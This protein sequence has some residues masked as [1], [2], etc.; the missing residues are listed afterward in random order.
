MLLEVAGIEIN[1]GTFLV[2]L[3]RML[4]AGIA[5]AALGSDAPYFT[6]WKKSGPGAAATVTPAPRRY[7]TKQKQRRSRR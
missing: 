1:P 4:L 7:V 2:G 6:V 5:P 3:T